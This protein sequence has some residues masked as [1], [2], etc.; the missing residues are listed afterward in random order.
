MFGH[1]AMGTS[2]FGD[3]ARLDSLLKHA[4]TLLNPCW[5]KGGLYYPRNDVNEDSEG[6]W[7]FV[8][9]FT[10]NGAIG[11][12][13]LN[14]ADGQK[15]MWEHAWTPE[16]VQSSVAVENISLA[17]DVDF[18][19]C[20]WVDEAEAGWKGLVMTMRTWN[21]E[22][23]AIHPRIAG[24]PAG[25]FSVFVDGSSSPVLAVEKGEDVKLRLEVGVEETTICI[26]Q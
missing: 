6:N 2:E 20:E 12:A 13:R 1:A 14:V 23:I 26:V 16:K 25:R 24:L 4:D 17:D 15:K 5:S 19:R 7:R 9:P 21:G 3:K 22:R 18:L 8:D 11:Y 10:A